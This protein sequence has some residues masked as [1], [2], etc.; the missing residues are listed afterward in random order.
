M[1]RKYADNNQVVHFENF[2]QS[3]GVRLQAGFCWPSNYRRLSTEGRDLFGFLTLL[4]VFKRTASSSL[5]N[6]YIFRYLNRLP[7]FSV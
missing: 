4:F 5:D 7:N 3:R 1:D 2:T 6:C